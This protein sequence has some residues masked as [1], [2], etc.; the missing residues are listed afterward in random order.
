[1]LAAQEG[2]PAKPG[3]ADAKAPAAAVDDDAAIDKVIEQ[4]L[5]AWRA[6]DAQKAADLLQKA[7]GMIQARAA[8]GLA[9]F[10]PTKAAGWTFE[11]PQVDSGAWGSGETAMQWS[12][13]RVEAAHGDDQRASL[14]ITNSPQIYQGMQAM[15][16][17]QA[18]MKAILAQQGKD[19]DVQTKS[20]FQ[21]LTI[22]DE[23][24]ANAWI[25]GK[26]IAVTIDVS[27]GDRATLDTVVGW[28]DL[29]GLQKLDGK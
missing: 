10:L 29:A 7:V 14:Q 13:A 28:F 22:V 3:A 18:Q 20:G 6:K 2:R 15:V 27:D 17:M 16:T 4:G 9:S 26:R 11:E 8:R 25:V 12:N 23:G 24:N 21:V 5:A 1:L 19:I